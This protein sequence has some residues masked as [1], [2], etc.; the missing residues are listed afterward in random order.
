VSPRTRDPFSVRDVNSC[1][2]ANAPN[3]EDLSAE[4]PI[5]P[6]KRPCDPDGLSL[7]DKIPLR[8]RCRRAL[9]KRPPILELRSSAGHAGNC[10]TTGV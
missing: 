9:W 2:Q 5:S 3:E 6:D 10:S 8:E 7:R 4:G 1:K